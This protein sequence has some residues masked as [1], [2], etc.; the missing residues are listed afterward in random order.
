MYYYF[1]Y[2]F[3]SFQNNHYL[4]IITIAGC[5]FFFCCCFLFQQLL[6]KSWCNL[7]YV[8]QENLFFIASYLYVFFISIYFNLDHNDH[9]VIVPLRCLQILASILLMKC[10]EFLFLAFV[11]G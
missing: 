3:F 4:I 5:S 1:Y 8:T 9:G 11:P 2:I 7:R 10:S 6:R